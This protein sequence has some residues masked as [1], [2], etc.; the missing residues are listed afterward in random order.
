MFYR[1]RGL[2]FFPRAPVCGRD[3]LMRIFLAVSS[4]GTVRVWC[5]I[6]LARPCADNKQN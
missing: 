2:L 6:S 3:F 5:K 1:G 4:S